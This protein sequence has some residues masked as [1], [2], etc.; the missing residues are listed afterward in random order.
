MTDQSA[1]ANPRTLDQALD[2]NFL[3]GTLEHAVRLIAEGLDFVSSA[4]LEEATNRIAAASRAARPPE[5]NPAGEAI[6][7]A[8]RAG[9]DPTGANIDP[10]A[11]TLLSLTATAAML[12]T[13]SAE[14]FPASDQGQVHFGRVLMEAAGATIRAYIAALPQ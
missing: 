11:G 8:A 7:Q 14:A 9:I 3:D 12:E 5:P 6:Y 1:A 4:C 10:E 2:Q 13:Y